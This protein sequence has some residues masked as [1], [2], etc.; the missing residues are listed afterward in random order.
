MTGGDG[1][2][3]GVEAA[4]VKIVGVTAVCGAPRCHVAAEIVRVE[5]RWP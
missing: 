3:G 5:G 2:G 4:G 1:H